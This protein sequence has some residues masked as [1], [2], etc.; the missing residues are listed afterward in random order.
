[1]SPVTVVEVLPLRIGTA[2][3]HP[4]SSQEVTFYTTVTRCM[5]IEGVEFVVPDARPTLAVT[6]Q[7][8][9]QNPGS[10]LSL[11]PKAAESLAD[12]FDTLVIDLSTTR[13]QGGAPWSSLGPE[14]DALVA[15]SVSELIASWGSESSRQVIMLLPVVPPRSSAARVSL[16]SWIDGNRL[17]LVG[18]NGDCTAKF[19][20]LRYS[21]LI[22]RLRGEPVT[23]LENK[24]VERR[25]WFRKS[26]R[27]SPTRYFRS[28]FDCGHAGRELEYLL[29]EELSRLKPDGPP[30]VVLYRS[31]PSRWLRD[32]LAAACVQLEVKFLYD[33][34]NA[35]DRAKL[36]SARWKKAKSAVLV[37]PY[38]DTGLTAVSTIDE[39][40]A[41]A[42]V[43]VTGIIS[44]LST[45]RWGSDIFGRGAVPRQ[46]GGG[47]VPLTFLRYVKQEF[48]AEHDENCHPR[49]YG[50][51]DSDTNTEPQGQL[52]AYEFW[53]LVLDSMVGLKAE[54]N[55]PPGERRKSLGKI[56]NFAAMVDKHG[57]WMAHRLWLMVRPIVNS[58]LR[59]GTDYDDDFSSHASNTIFVLPAEEAVSQR[60]ANH[61][62]RTI[63]ARVVRVPR[64]L[65]EE[66][67]RSANDVVADVLTQA[68]NSDAAW[69]LELR[70]AS[71][72]AKV[73]VL[74]D[75]VATGT[76]VDA[77]E[78]IVTF[79]GTTGRTV[80]LKVAAVCCIV[81]F[82]PDGRGRE[83]QVLSLYEWQK[84]A[85]AASVAIPS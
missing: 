10:I 21:E 76:T 2:S 16:N 1:M 59:S 25:G 8:L 61:V 65:I 29:G 22:T 27:N 12:E 64:A 63:G 34:D 4:I 85:A 35:A 18:D 3:W 6:V 43:S 44:V 54:V 77:L 70:G 68:W 47:S 51:P 42:P 45:K 53:D 24:I 14:V 30:Q 57:K 73:C 38:V 15:V 67:G 66:V 41:L 79:A 52:S 9:R 84:R 28:F 23:I 33:M 39:A 26:G 55:V 32:P 7:E 71:P 78:R 74:D 82:D 19:N 36:K 75:F 13:L 17:V 62:A 83:A 37:M 5:G 72:E 46:R 48:V 31:G 56:P 60:L 40:E 50:V 11:I 49:K 20:G 58:D 80:P 69:N 81:N